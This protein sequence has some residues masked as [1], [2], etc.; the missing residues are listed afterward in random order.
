M[1]YVNT[2]TKQILEASEIIAQ[3]A[4]ISLP[5]MGWDDAMLAPFD[6][7]ELHHPGTE[8]QITRFEKIVT[9][10]P[11]L[12]DDGKW[13]RTFIVESLVPSDPDQIPYF[14]EAEKFKLKQE[15]KA[16][17]DLEISYGTFWNNK[18]LKTDASSILILSNTYISLKDGLITDVTWK[19]ADNTFSVLGLSE[20]E[21]MYRTA[22]SYVQQQ[23]ILESQ[24]IDAINLITSLEELQNYI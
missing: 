24:T 23:F 10:I 8:P 22:V 9:G 17:R 15:A 12:H 19:N 21:E 7:A 5:N 20:I 6:L 1:S 4:N 18:P 11:E 14:V 16:K 2:K 3:F 13:Y